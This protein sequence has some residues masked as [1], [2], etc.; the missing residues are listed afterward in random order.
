M[1]VPMQPPG[2]FFLS[3]FKYH[4]DGNEQVEGWCDD[5]E[6]PV[7]DCEGVSTGVYE[8]VWDFLTVLLLPTKTNNFSSWWHTATITGSEVA[9]TCTYRTPYVRLDLTF[10]IDE[11]RISFKGFIVFARIMI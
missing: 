10:C 2:S 3:I 11:I 9:S 8:P 4:T 6:R 1:G 5:V 7:S